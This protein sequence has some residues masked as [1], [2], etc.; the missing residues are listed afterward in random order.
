MEIEKA[1]ASEA[2]WLDEM[3]KQEFP[4]TTFT[5]DKIIERINDSKH[6]VLVSKQKNI[7]TGFAE[8]E[9]FP[10]KKEARLNAVFVDD[11]WRDQKIGT[12]LVEQCINECKHKK[13]QRLFLLVK[14]DNLGAKH[15]YDDV[16]F[17][18]EKMH[19]KIIDESEVE[20]WAIKV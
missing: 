19:D 17:N 2:E 13:V 4:Y 5:P 7:L 11:G 20:I 3:I 10:D 18:F 16:G 1:K 8:L 14:K 15:L 12:A 6:L 9:F